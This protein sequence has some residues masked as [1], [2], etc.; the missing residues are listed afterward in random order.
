MNNF[1]SF[2]R[3]FD[4]AFFAPGALVLWLAH[5]LDYLGALDPLRRAKSLTDPDGVFALAAI[6]TATY[7]I[8]VVIHALRSL[9]WRLGGKRVSQIGGSKYSK[10][11][12]WYLYLEEPQFSEIQNYFWYMRATCANISV[13]FVICAI[14]FTPS[15]FDFHISKI[16]GIVFVLF[17]GWLSWSLAGD[18]DAAGKRLCSERERRFNLPQ[19][20]GKAQTRD[21]YLRQ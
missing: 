8:G 6:V 3:V 5:S 16:L 14:L 20:A 18:Y 17:S 1:L 15:L 4:L 10:K 19:E 2:F 7:A 11:N 9:I 13:A 21:E 12:S